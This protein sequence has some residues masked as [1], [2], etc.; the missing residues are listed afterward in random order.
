MSVS[1]ST[2][3]LLAFRSGDRCAFPE[4]GRALSVDGDQSNPVVTGEAAHIAGEKSGS[5]RF[6]GAMSEV[7][8]NHYNNLLY[9]CG[10]HHTQIDKLVEEFPVDRLHRMKA[11]H[12]AR[13]REAMTD[14]FGRV[15]FPELEEATNWIRQLRPGE[16]SLDFSVIPPEEKLKKNEL[17]NG[18]RLIVTMGLGLAREVRAYVESV[19][20]ADSDFPERLRIGFLDEY[21]R[22][23]KEGNRGDELFDLMCRFSQ[24]GLK[25]QA[26]RCAGL[27]VLV[28]LFE[29][30]EVFER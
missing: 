16:S 14:A 22:L 19:A 21:Y 29:A 7:Q 17:G 20:R 18:T 13:V 15:G 28:Y 3:V 23:R 9:L 30:C 24:R 26:G 4:C 6:D 5:A 12:E 2:K 25:D 27:A 10:D 8:R 1:Y 11:E